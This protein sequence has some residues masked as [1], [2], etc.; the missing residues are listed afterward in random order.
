MN[1]QVVGAVS[2]LL[3]NALAVGAL[4]QMTGCASYKTSRLL[5]AEEQEAAANQVKTRQLGPDEVAKLEKVLVGEIQSVYA[6][7]N[8]MARVFGQVANLGQKPYAAVTFEI[9]AVVDKGDQSSTNTV[10]TFTVRDLEPGSLKPFDVQT[11]AGMGDTNQLR[12]E[13]SGIR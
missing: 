1:R 3:L 11:A 4:T 6:A 7:D 12:V 8:G 13:V 5:S 2:I 10:A 9:V